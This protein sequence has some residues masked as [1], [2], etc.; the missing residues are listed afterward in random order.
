MLTEP[1]CDI[2]VMAIPCGPLEANCYL[3]TD[4]A[5][6]LC[7]VIDPG[8]WTAAVEKEIMARK[9]RIPYI[10]LTHGHFEHI[11]GAARV[12]KE[13]GAL[14][15]IHSQDQA[16][17]VDSGASMAQAMAYYAKQEPV[18][19]DRILKEGDLVSLGKTELL[20]LHTPGHSPGSVCFSCPGHLFSGDVLFR[21]SI[22]RT[23]LSGGDYSAMSASL[24]RLLK[25]TENKTVWPGHGPSTTL[26]RE[27]R[28]NPF[29]RQDIYDF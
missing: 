3:V 12:K 19:A 10:L 20:V 27:R 17:L 23:D 8:F 22:G 1:V 5:T 15:C 2:S 28:E 6:G 7:A 16:A 9:D 26:E 18:R 13:T 29:L 21:G 24:S 4:N 14:V 25:L 11:M